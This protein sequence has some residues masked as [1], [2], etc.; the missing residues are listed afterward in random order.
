MATA[1]MMVF[2]ISQMPPS[3]ALTFVLG[4]A[5]EA[6]GLISSIS[7][8]DWLKARRYGQHTDKVSSL[9]AGGGGL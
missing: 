2:S 7:G 5:S 3:L 4:W 8:S 1:M 9:S 6:E